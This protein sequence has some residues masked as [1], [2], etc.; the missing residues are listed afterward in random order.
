MN[1][2]LKQWPTVS[3]SLSNNH[4]LLHLHIKASSYVL[5]I[6]YVWRVHIWICRVCRKCKTPTFHSGRWADNTG[7]CGTELTVNSANYQS[8]RF[9]RS[10]CDIWGRAAWKSRRPLGRRRWYSDEGRAA[11]REQPWK[12]GLANRKQ[13]AFLR[14]NNMECSLSI[15]SRLWHFTFIFPVLPVSWQPLAGAGAARLP[16]SLSMLCSR[17]RRA[18]LRSAVEA[19]VSML[20]VTASVSCSSSWGRFA[21]RKSRKFV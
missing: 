20:L 3:C 15:S 4:H 9:P 10:T 11:V 5:L 7:I 2:S 12:A 8:C 17:P 13:C 14:Y 6:W 18:L 21:W 19:A 16:L 1:R